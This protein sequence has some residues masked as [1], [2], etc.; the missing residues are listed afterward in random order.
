MRIAAAAIA[1]LAAV[2]AEGVTIAPGDVAVTAPSCVNACI[3]T[4][5]PPAFYL[6]DHSLNVKSLR[7]GYFVAFGPNGHLFASDG[8]SVTEY[9][10]ALTAV[11]TFTRPAVS[12]AALTVDP[13]G[14]LFVLSFAGELTIYSPAGAVL[15]TISL[16]FTASPAVRGPSLDL[17]PDECTLFYTDPAQTGRRY[18]IC[19]QLPLANL[20][21]GSWNA[22]RAMSD[23][24]YAAASNSTLSI[25]AAHDQLLRAY[26]PQAGE[27]YAL[28]FDADPGFILLGTLN[29]LDRIRLADGVPTG[30][31]NS[32]IVALA[33]NGEQRPAAAPLATDIP[34]LSPPLL[35]AVAL[36][37]MALAWQRLRA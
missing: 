5:P 26:T 23:G 16:P 25:F 22:V 4:A 27:I 21:P 13:F 18:N 29:G 36:G 9:D 33:V 7:S 6:L 30:H 17:G 12:T 35:F 15:Q 31:F 3:A 10:T 37:L 32:I 20:P 34:A 1:L 14:N 11:H 28:A 2:A 24:G 8:G 19:A